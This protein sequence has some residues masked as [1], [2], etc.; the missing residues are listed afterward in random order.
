MAYDKRLTKAE[1]K[2][3]KSARKE[4]RWSWDSDE[5]VLVHLSQKNIRRLSR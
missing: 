5:P 1:R 4:F 3:I 2:S